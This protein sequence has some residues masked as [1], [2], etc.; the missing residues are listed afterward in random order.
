MGGYPGLSGWT[1][2]NHKAP[3]EREAG[4]Q[5]QRFKDAGLLALKMGP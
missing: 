1:Q 4:G 3:Y 5:T 2:C